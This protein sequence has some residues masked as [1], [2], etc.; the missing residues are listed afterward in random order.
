MEKRKGSLNVSMGRKERTQ[1]GG[2]L[3]FTK[4]KLQYTSCTIGRARI[5]I[6]RDLGNWRGGERDM[7]GT[8]R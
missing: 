5:E 6:D 7:S 2:F 8:S 4:T 1:L 3:A